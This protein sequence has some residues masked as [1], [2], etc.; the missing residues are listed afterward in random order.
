MMVL[1]PNEGRGFSRAKTQAE[2]SLELG[3]SGVLWDWGIRID[4]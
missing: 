2:R 3:F 1:K 4:V